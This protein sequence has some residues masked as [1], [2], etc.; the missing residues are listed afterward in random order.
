MKLQN[1]LKVKEK[2]DNVF[3]EQIRQKM[4]DE[5][6]FEESSDSEYKKLFILICK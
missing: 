4:C 6:Y 5:G 2:S 3:R 1:F